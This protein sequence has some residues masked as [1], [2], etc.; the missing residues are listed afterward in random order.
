LKE[1]TK[2]KDKKKSKTLEKQ[3]ERLKHETRMAIEKHST[4]KHLDSKE[5]SRPAKNAAKAERL[6]LKHGSKK[7]TKEEAKD[8]RKKEHMKAESV[9]KK[10]ELKIE[11]AKKNIDK[12]ES[13]RKDT[14]T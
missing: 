11:V 2:V 7:V 1:A 4:G 12:K 9:A 10:Q 3:K 14:K 5:F 8:N 13:A 6:E